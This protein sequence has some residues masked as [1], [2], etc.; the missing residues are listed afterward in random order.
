MATEYLYLGREN[1]IDLILKADGVAVDLSAVTQIKAVFNTVVI[2]STNPAAGLI[3]WA[4]GG[5]D[6]GE[7]RLDCAGDT[8]LETQGAGIWDVP[9]ITYDPSNTDGIQWGFVRIEVVTDPVT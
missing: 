3:K 7:I 5:Y 8:N 4:Q 6:T 2:S 9:I 1:T